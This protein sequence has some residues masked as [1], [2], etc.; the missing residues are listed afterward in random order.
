MVLHI[1][2]VFGV[3]ATPNAEACVNASV[4]VT[5]ILDLACLSIFMSGNDVRSI[6]ARNMILA[7]ASGVS[8]WGN[9]ANKGWKI[10]HLYAV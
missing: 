8:V 10:I 4:H 7:E 6:A 5:K 9:F 3:C 1:A 2:V